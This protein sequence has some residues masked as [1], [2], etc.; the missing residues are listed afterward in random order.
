MRLR[1]LKDKEIIMNECDFLI[2]DYTLLVVGYS[3]TTS[4]TMDKDGKCATD[5]TC[6]VLPA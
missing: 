1:N 5:T 3:N 2:T 6:D 4:N